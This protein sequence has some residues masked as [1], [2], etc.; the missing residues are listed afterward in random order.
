[1][2]QAPDS[3]KL[4]AKLAPGQLIALFLARLLACVARTTGRPSQA[5]L[6]HLT[7]NVAAAERLVNAFILMLTAEHLSQAGYAKLGHQMRTPCGSTSVRM[8]HPEAPAA[9]RADL[10]NRLQDCIENFENA[11]TFACALARILVCALNYREPDAQRELCVDLPAAAC[12][13]RPNFVTLQDPWR[14]IWPPPRGAPTT[15][16]PAV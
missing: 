15:A 7:Q 14:F 13:N 6:A 10:L 5:D 11:A 9:T 12:R 8:I 2:D 4:N 16:S 3:C 1:M